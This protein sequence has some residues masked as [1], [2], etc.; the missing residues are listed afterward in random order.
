M[1]KILM[2]G[3]IIMMF[4]VS[5]CNNVDEDIT[6]PEELYSNGLYAGCSIY[7]AQLSGY[8]Y[9]NNCGSLDDNIILEEFRN[10][11]VNI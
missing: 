11:C 5:G 6:S 3:L 8:C 7:A 10:L 1:N 9:D 4:I 2:I